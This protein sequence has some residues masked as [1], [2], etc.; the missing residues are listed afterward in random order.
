MASSTSH[1][2]LCLFGLFYIW[3]LEEWTWIGQRDMGAWDSENAINYIICYIYIA[4]HI[5]VGIDLETLILDHVLNDVRIVR[6]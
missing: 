4:H 3:N 5:L 6:L 1:S 2:D